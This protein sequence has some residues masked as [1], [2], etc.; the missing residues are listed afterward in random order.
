MIQRVVIGTSLAVGAY[1][2][3]PIAKDTF[4]PLLATGAK[5]AKSSVQ[6]IREE[7]EDIIFEAKLEKAQQQFEKELT[8]E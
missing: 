1:V 7:I 8:L 6:M 5:K 3:L 2:L 4:C